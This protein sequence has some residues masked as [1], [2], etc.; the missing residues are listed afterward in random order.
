MTPTDIAA[1]VN[2]MMRSHGPLPM[3]SDMGD[4]L[5]TAMDIAQHALAAPGYYA[6]MGFGVPAGLGIQAAT[7]ETAAGAG[8]RRCLPDDGLGLGN[9]RRYGWDPIVIVF[10]NASWEMLRAFQPDAGYND[11]DDW[12]FHELAAG[13][14]GWVCVSARAAS[15]RRRSSWRWPR[16]IGSCSSTWSWN[17]ATCRTR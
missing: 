2:D 15:W 4:C 1:A 14:V 16:A 10:N 8:G 11:L 12:P 7:G 13:L 6:G 17:A 3:A 9:C 5:F